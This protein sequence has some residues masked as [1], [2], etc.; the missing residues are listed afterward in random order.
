MAVGPLHILR[1]HDHHALF[2]CIYIIIIIVVIIIIIITII[3]I[4]IIIIIIKGLGLS[5]YVAN[6]QAR[7]S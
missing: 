7:L 1:S 4:I 2:P 3:I 5:S 6:A